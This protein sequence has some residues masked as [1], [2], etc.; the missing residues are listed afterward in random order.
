MLRVNRDAGA[1]LHLKGW[2]L[3]GVSKVRKFAIGRAAAALVTGVPLSTYAFHTGWRAAL[4]LG[5]ISP[6]PLPQMASCRDKYID[7]MAGVPQIADD[8][9]A[10]RKSAVLSQFRTHA[11]QQTPCLDV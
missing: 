8:F 5:G 7:L 6:L 1:G 4:R 2:V 11:Q 3:H 9:I 10:L